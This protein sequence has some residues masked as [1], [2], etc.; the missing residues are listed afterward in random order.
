MG[1]QY[2]IRFAAA[3]TAQGQQP[4]YKQCP[5][6]RAKADDP[7]PPHSR[8]GNGEPE[9]WGV[10]GLVDRSPISFS[11]K[12]GGHGDRFQDRTF[13][14]GEAYDR[15]KSRR[16]R[17]PYGKRRGHN[18]RDLG[19]IVL[20]DGKG[21]DRQRRREKNRRFDVV[22]ASRHILYQGQQLQRAF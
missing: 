12:Q 3:G 17:T 1:S 15:S 14:Q 19:R 7:G 5:V 2:K 13:I 8:K 4:H 18:Q 10:F 9:T 6:D 21:S 11:D 20:M 16:L 22:N